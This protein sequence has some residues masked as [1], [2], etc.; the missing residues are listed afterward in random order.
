ASLI[1]Y[2]PPG[3]GESRGMLSEIPALGG[4]L[5]RIVNSVGA[6]DLS[7]DGR[8]IAYFEFAGER[9]ELRVAARDGSGARAVAVFESGKS[10]LLAPRWSRDDRLIAYRRGY[11]FEHD[12]FVVPSTGGEPRKVTGK[13]RLLRGFAWRPD[14][15]GIV[16]SSPRGATTFYLPT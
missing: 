9:V 6:G 4:G 5:R 13:E 7:H 16:F 12:V 2:S 11:V 15:S 10:S 14:G 3:P 1:Y 8:Q